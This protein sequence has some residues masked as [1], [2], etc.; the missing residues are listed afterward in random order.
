MLKKPINSSSQLFTKKEEI[1]FEL[2]KILSEEK[3]SIEYLIQNFPNEAII[4][5][6]KILRT[7]G[8]LVF[9]GMGKSGLIARKL[10]ATFSSIGTPSFFLHPS[11][12][13]HGDLGMI[14]ENDFFI[15]ISKSGTGIELEQIIPI[16]KS[17][18]NQTCLISCKKG[19]L[20]NL[21]DLNIVLPFK[22]EACELNL[23]PTSSSTLSMA[24]G[25]AIAIVVGKLKGFNK[26][27]F[28]RFHPAG[29][30][31]K[32][33]LLK[34]S[35]LMHKVNQLPLIKPNT[36]FQDLIFTI[37]QKKLGVGIVVDNKIRLLGIITDGDLRRAC[38]FGPK[39]FN[40]TATEICTFH[41][42]TISADL[43]AYDALKVME[44]YNITSLIVT[45]KDNT[46]IGLIH[47]HDIIKAG[48]TS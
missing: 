3:N 26:N 35:A 24:F 14:Q 8:K 31:G 25:D 10:V 45:K 1:K 16:L 40:K 17:Q 15:A 2:I 21:V 27:D 47:I 5:V 11:E 4:L 38:K 33:L 29:A 42:K 9:C 41:T 20:N 12:A 22:K 46:V 28:A 19:I 18:N 43:L 48:I 30:L 39:I 32:K 37:T 36:N 23:A 6:E 7:K 44:D 13:L 34:V